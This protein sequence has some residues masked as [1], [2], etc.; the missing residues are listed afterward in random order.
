MNYIAIRNKDD[1]PMDF[2]DNLDMA[3]KFCLIAGI[4]H[5]YVLEKPGDMEP[6]QIVHIKK[7]KKGSEPP[8][9]LRYVSWQDELNK[10]R[11]HH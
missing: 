11:C 7:S 6:K 4:K 9:T 8:Y 5:L 3:V 10:C 2:G 1:M